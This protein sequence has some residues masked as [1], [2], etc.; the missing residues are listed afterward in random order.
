MLIDSRYDNS[1]RQLI[2]PFRIGILAQRETFFATRVPLVGSNHMKREA[3]GDEVAHCFRFICHILLNSQQ[4]LLFIECFSNQKHLPS[5]PLKIIMLPSIRW[6]FSANFE[7]KT[8]L[9]EKNQNKFQFD[10]KI[11]QI[12]IK[13]KTNCGDPSNPIHL[14]Q[15]KKIFWKIEINRNRATKMPKLDIAVQTDAIKC[16][17]K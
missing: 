7:I 5:P 3:M 1:R 17:G 8:K 10:Y 6:W 16:R 9:T 13:D 12:T 2:T 11:V 14:V 15:Q 4:T